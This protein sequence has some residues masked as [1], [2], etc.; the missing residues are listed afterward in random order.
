MTKKKA[1]KKIP[2][3][4]LKY[5]A[6]DVKRAVAN[7]K[8]DLEIDYGDKLSAKD[9]E[10]LNRFQE[11]YVITNFKH[12]GEL[13][14][15]SVDYRRERWRYNNRRNNDML[16]NAKTKNLLNRVDSDDHMS[17]Y[18]NA[19]P[20]FYNHHEDHVIGIIDNKHTIPEPVKELEVKKVRKKRKKKTKR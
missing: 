14:D 1:Y 13:L 3:N 19:S 9:K 11:E 15:D 6:L 10:W 12:K 20:T 4:K 17:H 5:P 18:M 8:D 7:R 2:R 16:L